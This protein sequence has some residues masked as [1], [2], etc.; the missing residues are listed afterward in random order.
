MRLALLI[1]ILWLAVAA[2][3]D[4]PRAPEP[5]PRDPKPGESVKLRGTLGEDVDCRLFRSEAG[6]TYSIAGTL[7]GLP[8]GSKICL[9]AT[10]AE[11]SQCLTT[12]T[13]EV[14]SVRPWSSCP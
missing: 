13:L 3:C 11:A 2:R 12:P 6:K 1:G 7:R 10:V 14:Q 4:E 8:N 9:Y 5:P